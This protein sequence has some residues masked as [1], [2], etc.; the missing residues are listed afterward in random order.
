MRTL[1]TLIDRHGVDVHP[2][3]DRDLTIPVLAGLQRQGDVI[4][5]PTLVGPE[6]RVAVPRKGVPVVRGEATGNTHLLL[7]EGDV[8]LD[9]LDASAGDL[10]LG[11]LTVAEGSTAH[12]AHA[13]HGYLSI[14]P[15]TY[16][17]RRQREQADEIRLVQ[18]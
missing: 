6:A 9:M 8:R 18:D 1:S 14:A 5:I 13:E 17:V 2:H 10:L 12:M 15:G 3:L 16:E 4:V 11:R 7:A